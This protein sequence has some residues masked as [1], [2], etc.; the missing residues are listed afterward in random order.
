MVPKFAVTPLAIDAEIPT[1]LGMAFAGTF[2]SR[3]QATAAAVVPMVPVACQPPIRETVG[4]ARL[5]LPATSAAMMKAA[6][7]SA[8]VAPVAS[9]TGR[10]AGITAAIDCPAK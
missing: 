3:A 5:I 1:M 10:I 7:I 2:M 6:S 9:A 4:A 8:A